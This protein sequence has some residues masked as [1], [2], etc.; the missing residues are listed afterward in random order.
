M[1]AYGNWCGPG[2]SAGQYK[3]AKELTAEDY[4]IPAVDALDQ[5][6]KDHDIM[7]QQHPEDA[8]EINNYFYEQVKSLGVTGYLFGLAVLKF[9]P[10]YDDSRGYPG[11]ESMD[12]D[13]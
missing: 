6:C 2:W 13:M 3:D 11:D 1:R 12:V 8:E 4:D 5:A 9:G 7:L 10:T